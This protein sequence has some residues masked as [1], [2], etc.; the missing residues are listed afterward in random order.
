MAEQSARQK[1]SPVPFAAPSS[2]LSPALT[3]PSPQNGVSLQL[4]TSKVQFALQASW[5]SPR[6]RPAQVCPESEVPSHSSLASARSLPQSEQSPRSKASQL[7]AHASV[8]WLKPSSLQVRLPRSPPSQTSLPSIVPLPQPLQPLR[9]KRQLPR[10]A[11][12]P[13]S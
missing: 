13:P 1:P 11:S 9:S 12:W 6:P 4:A 5:P 10:Q 3:S 2:Q 8:P 7:A